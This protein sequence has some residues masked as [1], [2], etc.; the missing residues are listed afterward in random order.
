MT[1]TKNK[2]Q[3]QQILN[4]MLAGQK[5][6]ALKAIDKF[7]CLRLASRI[8]EI[9]STGKYKIKSEFIKLKSGKR[10]KEYSI[11]L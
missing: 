4:A 3:V 6:T 11:P 2:S 7:K 10:V 1:E 5:I 9:K 8:A